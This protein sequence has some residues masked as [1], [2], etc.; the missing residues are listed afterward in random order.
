MA[1][2]G[3][4]PHYTIS[5]L[6]KKTIEGGKKTGPMPPTYVP[7]P[8]NS[9]NILGMYN[10]YNSVEKSN[11]SIPIPSIV[12][13]NKVSSIPP[14]ISSPNLM[15]NYP[16]QRSKIPCPPG[17]N[18]NP[19]NQFN[20]IG[21][22]NGS[23][24]PI[25]S[26]QPKIPQFN[27]NQPNVPRFQPPQNPSVPANLPGM[28]LRNLP[29]PNTPL[30]KF[31]ISSQINLPNP[32]NPITLNSSISSSSSLQSSF[33]QPQLPVLINE[34]SN[35][36]VSKDISRSSTNINPNPNSDITWYYLDEAREFLPYQNSQVIEAAFQKGD[37]QIE[38][39]GIVIVFGRNG[40]PHIQYTNY[41][42]VKKTVR[43]GLNPNNP[44]NE[45]Y[46]KWY[47][48]DEK[49]NHYEPEACVTIQYYYEQFLEEYGNVNPGAL[50]I[51]ERKSLA[52][53]ICV[54]V[55]GTSK[56]SYLIDFVNMVQMNE[57]TGRWRGI[58]N[59]RQ[60]GYPR[61]SP[62]GVKLLQGDF[63]IDKVEIPWLPHPDLPN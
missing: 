4:N 32:N 58:R 3:N 45:N 15:Q 6:D 9:P 7:L 59:E 48:Y 26:P 43:R 8:Q 17:V 16:P 36:I 19:P 44:S 13:E 39:N 24:L 35:Q 25:M 23:N 21:N 62:Q 22:L 1:G 28:G 55:W 42:N 41:G 38:F 27:I 56:F 11:Q 14:G 18:F 60:N 61:V 10:P 33:I 63:A 53:R 54:L 5:T 34:P 30:P 2:F 49:W 52:K 51:H 29:S 47:Y 20:P 46:I 50:P 12:I 31:P 40:D 57:Q 37:S